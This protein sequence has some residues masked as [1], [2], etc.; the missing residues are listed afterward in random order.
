MS[1]HGKGIAALKWGKV[2]GRA[3]DGACKG[4]LKGN[5]SRLNRALRSRRTAYVNLSFT[6]FVLL[7]TQSRSQGR[8]SPAWLVLQL[9]DL[10]VLVTVR[11]CGNRA[12][13]GASCFGREEWKMRCEGFMTCK[14]NQGSLLCLKDSDMVLED[15]LPLRRC[16]VVNRLNGFTFIYNRTFVNCLFPHSWVVLEQRQP[17]QRSIKHFR[18]RSSY[19]ISQCWP[20]AW[21]YG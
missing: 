19:S 6:D 15:F 1:Q 7:K 10:A 11:A 14:G 13:F 12:L 4:N 21:W 2:A 9:I 17:W 20:T 8:F 5:F 3:K 16:N 18:C